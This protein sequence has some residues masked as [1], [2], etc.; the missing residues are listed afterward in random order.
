MALGF[1]LILHI[2]LIR[3]LPF[4]LGAAPAELAP[5]HGILVAVPAGTAVTAFLTGFLF[6]V[7]CKA[8]PESTDRLIA[9][10]YVF[11]ALGGLAAG[12]LFTFLLV[13]LL[14]PLYIIAATALIIGTAAAAYAKSGRF[15]RG[16]AGGAV[17]VAAGI[18]L[19]SPLGGWLSDWSVRVR[20]D[21]LHPGL[22]L[23]FSQPTRYQQVE[24]A[25]L[26]KQYSLFGDGKIVSSFPDPHSADRLTA[27]I[28]APEA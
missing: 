27:L 2:V 9:R 6:P 7:G 25:Q 22:R 15:R 10:L 4:L 26:G 1:S 21:F 14:S 16:I 12:L 24:I 28:M 5:L 13:R 17:L 23:L 18:L 8:V 19:F 11:E 3:T 20:W